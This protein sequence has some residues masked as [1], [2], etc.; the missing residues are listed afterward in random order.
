MIGWFQIDLLH[1]S[2]GTAKF[3]GEID[4]IR[5]HHKPP[6]TTAVNTNYHSSSRSKQGD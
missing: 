1:R 4:S 5:S 2:H 3:T 6:D